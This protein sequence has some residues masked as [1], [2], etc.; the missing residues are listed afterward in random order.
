MKIIVPKK[1][2]PLF[3]T[4]SVITLM[5]LFLWL[6]WDKYVLAPWTRDGRIRAEVVTIA[7]EVAG[8][9]IAVKVTDN[10]FVHKGDVLFVI[11]PIRFQLALDHAEAELAQRSAAKS[12]TSTQA[13]RRNNIGSDAVSLDE[14][15]TYQSESDIAVAA[16]NEALADR[17]LARLN[18]NRS[19]LYSPVDGFI[20]NLTLRVGD[21][22]TAKTPQL[23]IVDSNSFYILG[24]F[25]ETKLRRIRVGARVTARL[26]EGGSAIGGHVEGI[27]RGITDLNTNPDREGLASVDPVF[28]WVRLAQRIPVRIHIDDVPEGIFV[29]SGLT[30]T[31]TVNETAP[32]WRPPQPIG[33]R[34]GQA[35]F[36]T[37]SHSVSVQTR[38][39][40]LS[41]F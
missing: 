15:Q 31:I 25:E 17:D 16:Y 34:V 23:S 39:F 38:S 29:S 8:T 36:P 14:K 28:T 4:I 5:L 12:V 3:R 20:T 13:I 2:I 30:C 24:Y 40:S 35:K 9:V 19:T 27:S 41:R 1:A 6:I 26:L 37:K 22:A 7:P 32:L 33:T 21:F 10:Q 11:D 18:L